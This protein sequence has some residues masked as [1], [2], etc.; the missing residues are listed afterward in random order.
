MKLYMQTIVKKLCCYALFSVVIVLKLEQLFQHMKI[1]W[2]T[3]KA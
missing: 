3:N 2:F 1:V